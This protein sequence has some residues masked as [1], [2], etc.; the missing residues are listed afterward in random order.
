MRQVYLFKQSFLESNP[1]LCEKR[2]KKL[3]SCQNH[4]CQAVC[5]V[6]TEHVCLQENLFTVL[7][8]FVFIGLLLRN[9]LL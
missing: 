7:F 3:K 6:E 8:L 2:C 9:I 4:R 1:L 5:C